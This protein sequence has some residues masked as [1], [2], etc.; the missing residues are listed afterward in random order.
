MKKSELTCLGRCN[1]LGEPDAIGSY[2]R[3]VCSNDD[4]KCVIVIS[5]GAAEVLAAELLGAVAKHDD[6]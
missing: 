4:A 2:V 6:Y 1:G 5:E 3:L